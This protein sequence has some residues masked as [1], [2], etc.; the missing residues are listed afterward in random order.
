MIKKKEIEQNI[1]RK[2][3]FLNERH[4]EGALPEISLLNCR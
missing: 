3:V 1:F 2:N 4:K